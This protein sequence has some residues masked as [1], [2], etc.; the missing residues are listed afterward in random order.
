MILKKYKK[1]I[2]FVLIMA[3]MMSTTGCMDNNTAVTYNNT[4]IQMDEIQKQLDFQKLIIEAQG[5][6]NIWSERKKQDP[7]YQE[8]MIK[9]IATGLANN[10]ILLDYAKTNNIKPNKKEKKEIK[11]QIDELL[12]KINKKEYMKKH[13]V[14]DKFIEK[15]IDEKATAK[16]VEDFLIKKGK[17]SND[18]I[19]K[20]FKE[21]NIKLKASHILLKTSD[22][23][24]KPLDPKQEKEIKNKINDI[25]KEV[26]KNPNKFATIAKEKS[27]DTQSAQNN[28]SIGEFKKGE[29]I[30]EFEKQA[31]K[32]KEGEISKPIKTQFGYHIIKIDKIIKLKLS[33]EKKTIIEILSRQKAKEIYQQISQGANIKTYEPVLKKVRFNTEKK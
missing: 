32:M 3:I 6:N 4:E 9:E 19:N 13:N 14:T 1:A 25:Y 30:E 7:K 16:A 11:K 21:H 15:F 33:D 24:G 28:G 2:P 5:G 20:Y 29:M 27:E 22:K 8:N 26:S 17:P 23:N 12:K 18:E 10:H 31:F